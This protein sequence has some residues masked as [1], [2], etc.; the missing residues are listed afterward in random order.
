MTMIRWSPLED[1]SLLRN[2]LDNMFYTSLPEQKTNLNHILPVELIERGNE[3]TVRLALPGI[4]LEEI[5]IE[6]TQKE[7]TITAK[8]E[9]R[10][11]DKEE[12]VHI[13][14]FPYGSFSKHL[15]FPTGINTEKVAASY[16]LGI[17]TIR[18]P[19]IESAQPRQ[20]EITVP[21]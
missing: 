19:K 12:H 15:T 1:M 8:K 18:V 9:P 5:K 11:L 4:P 13:R 20:I 7:L 21:Q 2:Q 3:Y 10:E 17:I 14:E 6:A 16:D